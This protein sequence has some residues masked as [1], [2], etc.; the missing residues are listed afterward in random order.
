M[1]RGKV[2]SIVL[3][4]TSKRF[5]FRLISVQYAVHLY[6]YFKEWRKNPH[7]SLTCCLALLL[8][9]VNF[10][11]EIS[12]LAGTNVTDTQLDTGQ[13]EMTTVGDA[14]KDS[15]AIDVALGTKE[16]DDDSRKKVQGEDCKDA[17]LQNGEKETPTIL[18]AVK[19]SG[20]FDGT[21][22]HGEEG[23]GIV[24]AI[25]KKCHQTT[26]TELLANFSITN[27]SH[28]EL[29]KDTRF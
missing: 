25:N 9:L 24:H 5:L 11:G 2:W 3:L 13:M 6:G 22:E 4:V 12:G 8:P 29:V 18:G 14:V 16:Q 7:W 27:V 15:G 19:D 23:E 26:Q 17:Q 1:F 20:D 21:F 10:A 28:H